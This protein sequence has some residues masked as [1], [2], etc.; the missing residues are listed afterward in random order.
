[1]EQFKKF[2]KKKK[3]QRPLTK[4]RHIM[5]NV[6]LFEIYEKLIEQ[7]IKIIVLKMMVEITITLIFCQNMSGILFNQKLIML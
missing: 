2:E 3:Y 6:I 4:I 1:M 7:M 5:W